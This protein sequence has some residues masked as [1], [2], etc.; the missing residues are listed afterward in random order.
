M[1]TVQSVCRGM[2][3]E[4]LDNINTSLLHRGVQIVSQSLSLARSPRSQLVAW[5]RP[6]EW[7]PSYS[8]NASGMD[9][10][11]KPEQVGVEAKM[12]RKGL[13]QK[14]LVTQLAKDILRYQSHQDCKTLMCFV[15]DPTAK[16]SNPT[17][18][19]NDL[20]KKQPKSR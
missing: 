6:E 17:A 4:H 18:L 9:F 13:G 5:V 2:G 1:R 8:G 12:A 11:L 15:Y 10:L 16:C 14:E 3:S 19:E 20:T 7:T